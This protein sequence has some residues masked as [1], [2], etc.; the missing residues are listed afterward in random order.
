L[1]LVLLLWPAAIVAVLGIAENWLRLR[2]RANARRTNKR[3]D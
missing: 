2:D 3:N 1:F